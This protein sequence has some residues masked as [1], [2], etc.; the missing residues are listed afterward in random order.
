MEKDK[1]LIGVIF[2]IFYVLFIFGCLY[3]LYG[4]YAYSSKDIATISDCFIISFFFF[5]I[6]DKLYYLRSK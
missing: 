1:N 4:R 5:M 2:A 6:S 3:Y